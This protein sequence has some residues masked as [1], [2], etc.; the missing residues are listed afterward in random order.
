[1]R[2]EGQMA[3]IKDVAKKAQVSTATVSYV[4]NKSRYVSPELTDRVQQA[5]KEL[6]FAPSKIAQ[7]LRAG[8]TFTIGLIADDITNRFASQFTRGLENAA[9]ENQYSIII[10]DLQEKRENESRSLSMLVDRKVDGII[11]AGFGEVE[12][13][14]QG[15]NARGIP[16]VIVDKPLDSTALPSVL[17][18]NRS[19]IVGALTYLAQ[20]GRRAII[21]INGLAINRNAILRAAAFQ[22]FMASEG[23]PMHTDSIIY[24]DYTLQHGYET[25]LGLV[26]KGARFT[27]LL[28]GDDTIAFGA[29]AALKSLGVRVPEDVAVI[30]FDDDPM[31]SV[32]DPSLT[33][34]H[35][36]IYEM[37]R[38]S[39]QV[40]QKA[41]GGKRKRPEHILLETQ[42]IIRRST[43]SSFRD[44]HTR[45]EG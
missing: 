3:T 28:C 1:M 38:L 40:F 41:A 19:G 18:D 8:K 36:P 39:F 33:T 12:D 2:A 14:L 24:G 45:R 26:R 22:D 37:G 5:I 31:A 16:V 30:G 11:Y 15:L 9:S 7:G 44:Y 23:L 6:S 13:E 20:I 17:I 29:I 4:V 32:F 25:T 35:Y 27:A 10:S 42:L 34:V 43:D 21:Y